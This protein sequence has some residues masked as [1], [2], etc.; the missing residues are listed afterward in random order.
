[1][2]RLTNC[3]PMAQIGFIDTARVT[4]P[5]AGNISLPD[6]IGVVLP[7][8]RYSIAIG[9][10]YMYADNGNI[11]SSTAIG[12]YTYDDNRPHAVKTVENKSGSIPTISQQVV[13]NE[14]NLVDGIMEGEGDDMTDLEYYLVQTMV[15]GTRNTT[16][17][18]TYI[19]P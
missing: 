1:M 13:Y 9:D 2:D 8:D 7:G 14:L 15:A 4:K 16:R 6:G 11:L 17:A 12:S 19:A 10:K 5:L 18:A 3:I